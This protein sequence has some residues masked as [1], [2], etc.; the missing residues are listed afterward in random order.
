MST[1]NRNILLAEIARI[2]VRIERET[3]VPAKML[4]AQWAVESEWGAEPIGLY[5]VFGIKC[6][7]RHDICRQVTTHEVVKGKRVKVVQMFADFPSLEAA[8]RDYAWIIS[9]GAAYRPYWDS[10]LQT[11]NVDPLIA[12]VAKR[13]AT[14]P[15][16]ACLVTTISKQRNVAA[17][18]AEARRG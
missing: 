12:G 8:C 17:A 1:P 9:H 14:D 4:I 3:R 10:F 2:A 11:G 15:N 18:I 6:A 7:S 5:N 16:Y 13:Y